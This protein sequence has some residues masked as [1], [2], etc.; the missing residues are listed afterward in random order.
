M[1]EALSLDRSAARPAS[2]SFS[3]VMA[4][5]CDDVTRQTVVRIAA[6]SGWRQ[7]LVEA[8]GIGAAIEHLTGGLSPDLLFI[9]LSE[10]DNP[11]ADVNSL[12][13]VCDPGTR[14][15]AF[16][17]ANDVKLYRGLVAAGMVDYL[18][19]PVTTADILRAVSEA[20]GTAA[21]TQSRRHGRLMLVTGTRGGVGATMFATS[22]AWLAAEKFDHKT[23]L[24]D[25]DLRF[26]TG[27][28]TFDA[29]PGTGVSDM[30]ADPDRI[31]PL[32]L[33]RASVGVGD[34]LALFATEA[35]L[36]AAPPMRP[37]A[38]KVLAEE[39][40]RTYQWVIADVP[41]DAV[42]SQ[43]DLIS[44][45]DVVV[46][47]SDLSLAAMRDALRLRALVAEY[48]PQAR[49]RL[50]GNETRPPAKGDL[51]IAEFEKTLGLTFTTRI[52]L[53]RKAIG[54]SEGRGRPVAAGRGK[55]AA[56]VSKFA[57]DVFAPEELAGRKKASWGGKL[58]KG[59]KA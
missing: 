43:P 32:F 45:A 4:F 35:P 30:L 44:I 11:L 39:L 47:V 52:P 12:A 34:K 19:K 23:A 54:D 5:L 51:P 27:A 17:T 59:K 16:G 40:L 42:A 7:P 49:L 46:L 48:G 31:D 38:L 24:F 1:S 57:R 18:V 10:S 41:R 6:D 37:D 53:D 20:A 3:R 56:V 14:V 2:Q 22:M 9:D 55:A 29:E 26:G 25:L 15:V 13:D 50:I 58:F 21:E 33:E 28:L 36:A 8:G